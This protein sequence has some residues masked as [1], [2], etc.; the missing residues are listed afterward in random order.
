MSDPG[1][2]GVSKL[3]AL[4]TPLPAR[5]VGNARANRFRYSV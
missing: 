1:A 3:A 5:I 4:R 2:I